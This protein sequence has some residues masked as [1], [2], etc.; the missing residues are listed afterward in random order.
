MNSQLRPLSLGELLD[1]TFQLYRQHFMLFVGIV[2]LPQLVLLTAQ[3]AGTL[4]GTFPPRGLS[5]AWIWLFA[6]AVVSLFAAMMIQGATIVAVSQLQLG[7]PV[8]IGLAYERVRGRIVSL[9]FLTL[10]IGFLTFLGFILLII[11]G[12]LLALRWSLAVPAAVLE[13]LGVGPAM[14]RSAD[15]TRGDRGRVFMIYVLYFFLVLVGTSIWQVPTIA[16]TFAA[17]R[18]GVPAPM[19]TLIVNDIGVF[20]T[21]CL[22]SPIITIAIS[23]LYYD[24]RVRKEAFDLQHM[25]A[26]LGESATA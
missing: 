3:L 11:P 26:E 6:L 24:E 23:L 21:Q 14:S 5:F 22:I 13:D 17:A 7:R 2:A 10:G 8:S 16:A 25:M 19:W 15:L 18:A 20:F 1:R 9:V 4:V 12:V